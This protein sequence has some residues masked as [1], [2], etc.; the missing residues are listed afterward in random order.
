MHF[1]NLGVS[2]EVH[3]GQAFHHAYILF[4]GGDRD[5]FLDA[6]T[7]SV[8]LYTWRL[9]TKEIVFYGLYTGRLCKGR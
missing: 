7:D 5:T 2:V 4:T 9:C 3:R 6:L 1:L 8:D